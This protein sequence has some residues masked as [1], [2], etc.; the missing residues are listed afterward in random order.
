MKLVR[1]D[2]NGAFNAVDVQA[3]RRSAV[4]RRLHLAWLGGQAV[5]SHGAQVLAEDGTR[6]AVLR[7]QQGEVIEINA[8]AG[9]V[10]D[11]ISIGADLIISREASGSQNDVAMDCLA[12][13]RRVG[14]AHRK[15]S[16]QRVDEG[17]RAELSLS[18]NISRTQRR[19]CEV[20]LHPDRKAHAMER[21]VDIRVRHLDATIAWNAG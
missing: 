18:T 6:I 15:T 17:V 19:Q 21:V 16:Q 2:A 11:S 5:S 4:G 14:P 20:G 1:R 8:P 12:E 10:D 3:K 7:A 9:A 13:E